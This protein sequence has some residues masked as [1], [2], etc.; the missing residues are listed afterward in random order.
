MRTLR[1]GRENNPARK[2][3]FNL[4]IFNLKKK[5]PHWDKKSVDGQSS[6][7]QPQGHFL[8]R[9]IVMEKMFKLIFE[10]N[11]VSLNTAIIF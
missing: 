7:V 6:T 3:A 8:R 10:T 9:R 1:E 5:S 4:L 2:D 11:N